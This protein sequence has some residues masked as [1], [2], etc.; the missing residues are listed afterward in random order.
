MNIKKWFIGV[1]LLLA[2]ILVTIPTSLNVYAQTGVDHQ[3]VEPVQAIEVEM[4]DNFFNPK[5]IS[6]PN[7]KR[8]T[9]VLKNKGMREHTFTVD[10]LGIDAEVQPGKEMTI[11]VEPKTPGTYELICRYHVQA[12]MV[13]KVMVK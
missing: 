4:N 2:V 10:K 11:T 12:G 5:V 7:G 6:I 8:T 3:A 9:L 13:G 1:A